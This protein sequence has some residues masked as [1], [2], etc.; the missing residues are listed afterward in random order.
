MVRIG[1]FLAGSG[2]W[3]IGSFL[4]GGAHG[5][6]EAWDGPGYWMFGVPLLLLSQA[7]ATPWLGDRSAL[8]PAWAIAGHMAAMLVIHPAGTDL[9]LLPLAMMFLGLPAYGALYLAGML[10]R[11]VLPA[12]QA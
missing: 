6:R 7:A 10:G 8:Q 3:A 5:I 11:A 9:G 2:L 4:A 12:R 1:L